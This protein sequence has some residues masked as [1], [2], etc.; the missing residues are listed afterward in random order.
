MRRGVALA[1]LAVLL[2]ALGWC[3]RDA[4][5]RVRAREA[6]DALHRRSAALVGPALCLRRGAS[7]PSREAPGVAAARPYA[8]GEGSE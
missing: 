8:V 7:S 4:R 2:L 5:R 3:V 1:S 6:N